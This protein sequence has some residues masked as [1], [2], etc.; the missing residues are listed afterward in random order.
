MRKIII[1]GAGFAGLQAAKRLTNS[2]FDLTVIDPNDG[3][4][5]IILQSYPFNGE[6][7]INGTQATYTPYANFNGSA[8]F[9]YMVGDGTYTSN[10]AE[11]SINR[12]LLGRLSILLNSSRMLLVYFF[13]RDSL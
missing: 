4:L 8:G 12:S 3:N 10:L 7:S 9:V 13:I 11:V 1:V 5:E 6:I 2:S